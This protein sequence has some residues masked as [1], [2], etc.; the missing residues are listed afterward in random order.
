MGSSIQEINKGEYELVKSANERYGEYY[1]ISEEYL[2]IFYNLY[3]NETSEA[4][5]FICFYGLIKKSLLLSILS[6]LRKHTFQSTYNLRYALEATL[7]T[8]YSL[9]KPDIKNFIEF[10]KND[11]VNFNRHT[12]NAS[13]WLLKNYTLITQNLFNLQKFFSKMYVHPNIATA[14]H[15]ITTL[16]NYLLFNFYDRYTND[17]VKSQLCTINTVMGGIMNLLIM[18]IKDY[19]LVTLRNE[20][21]IKLSEL[22]K[23][24]KICMTEIDRYT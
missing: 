21:E 4:E 15:N 23:R 9:Y 8:C 12:D 11:Q 24:T 20:I 16:H 18:V 2:E 10:D 6:T 1:L 14:D 13:K 3:H 19:P 7:R 5:T 22:L 17:E